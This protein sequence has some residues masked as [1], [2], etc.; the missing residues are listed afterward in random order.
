MTKFIHPD[1]PAPKH[2]LAFS[3]TRVD[4]YSKGAYASFNLGLSVDD[5]KNAV[6]KNRELL[7]EFLPSQPCWIKQV[8]GN[9]VVNAS[10]TLC[11]AD[12][13][14]TTEKNTPCIVQTADCLPILICN[15][16]GDEIAA[17]HGG[18]RSLASKII[19]NTVLKLASPRHE[20]LVWLGPAIGPTK[21]EVG[22]E[23]LET[24]CDINPKLSAA[25]KKSGDHKFLANLYLIASMQFAELGIDQ[26][27]G[28]NH[29]TYL[30]DSLFYSYRRD[31]I[32]GR[33]ASVISIKDNQHC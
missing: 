11:E 28:G 21:F 27:Y 14:Y 22:T 10:T 6:F 23:V 5:E 26:I 33:M 3:T 7:Q 17:I 25:F 2:I 31:K 13:S 20:L 4:G 30:E 16:K 29:C 19:E 8:H 24:F 15:K 1:W 32:T 18:W 9:H 12:A